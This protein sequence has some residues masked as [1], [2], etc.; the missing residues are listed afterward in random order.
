V[1]GVLFFINGYDML[2]GEESRTKNLSQS[3]KESFSDAK[4]KAITPLA[5]PLICG[6]GTITVMAVMIQESETI[7]QRGTLFLC[8]ALIC[9]ATYYVLVGSQRIM[10]LLGESGRKVFF[11]LMGLILMMIAVEFF[12]KGLTPYVHALLSPPA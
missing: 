9:I 6:P 3:E 12:F 4:V 2:K 5:I 11:R 7:I 10:E 8:A 1:G